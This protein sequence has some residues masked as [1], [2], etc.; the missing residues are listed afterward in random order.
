MT[1]R[2]VIALLAGA[3]TLLAAAAPAATASAATNQPVTKSAAKPQ[4]NVALPGVVS[5]TPLSYT[6][7]VYAGP[8]CGSLCSHS[9]VYSTVVVNGEVV[10]AGVFGNVCSP[11]SGAYAQCPN[12]VP[13]DYIFAF[14][15]ATGAIDPNFKPTFNDPIYSLAAGPNNT[16]YVGGA[17]TTVNGNSQRG[18]TQLNVTPGQASTDGT[19]V[20]KFKAH[21]TNTV[22]QVALNGNALYLGGSFNY[23][24]GV[25]T[26]AVGRVNATTGAVDK[27]FLFTVSDPAV[28]PLDVKS[29]TL[30][31]NGQVLAIAGSFLQVN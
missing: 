22:D 31:P 6:P 10:V 24:N 30:S 3:L 13:A 25:K 18:V 19:Q 15:P 20:A 2:R 1:S 5:Q 7:N 27:S 23:I 9:E 12:T 28:K 26:T 17:F 4:G 14:N 8:S 16:V 21:T 11:V 29:M